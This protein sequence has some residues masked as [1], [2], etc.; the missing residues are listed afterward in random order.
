MTMEIFVL[1]DIK[2]FAIQIGIFMSNHVK[3]IGIKTSIAPDH[4]SVYLCLSWPILH[5]DRVFWKFNKTLLKDENYTSEICELIPR[6]RE[7]HE[8]LE[9]KRLVCKLIKM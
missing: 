6:I 4:K 1:I 8:C 5:G 3:N 9:D 7:K 2:D